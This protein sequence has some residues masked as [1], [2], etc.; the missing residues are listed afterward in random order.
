[1]NSPPL[2]WEGAVLNEG[3]YTVLARLG[4]GGMST[5]FR[6][7]DHHLNTD[8]VIKVPHALSPADPAFVQ[9]FSG[10]IRSLVHLAHPH[11]VQILDAG[12]HDGLPFAVL[13]YLSGGSLRGRQP[14]TPQGQ[15]FAMPPEHLRTWLAPVASA[16]DFIHQQGYVHRD[17]KPD[18]ILFDAHGN[19]YVAD[20]GVARATLSQRGANAAHRTLVGTP[21][22]LAPELLSGQPI[23]GQADQY[24]L[25]VTVHE[26]LTGR[27]PHDGP[28]PSLAPELNAALQKALAQEPS[29]R[30]PSCAAFAQAVLRCVKK[31]PA[32]AD[33]RDSR[34]QKAEELAPPMAALPRSPGVAPTVL[35]EAPPTIAVLPRRRWRK[36][37]W[38]AWGG[39]LAVALAAALMVILLS[40]PTPQPSVE[41]DAP[42]FTSKEPARQQPPAS[43]PVVNPPPVLP[44]HP[45]PTLPELELAAVP[46]TTLWAGAE[47]LVPVAVVRRH[48][49]GPI[50]V[51]VQGLPPLVTAAPVDVPAGQ[52]KTALPLRAALKALPATVNYRIVATA[53]KRKAEQTG[54][55]AVR[56]VG[57]LRS[58]PAPRSD[59]LALFLPSSLQA[60]V[61]GPDGFMRIV[62]LESGKI[63]RAFEN[64]RVAPLATCL[65]LSRDGRFALSGRG[66]ELVLWDVAGGQPER[67]F[68]LNLVP[69]LERLQ[70]V[71]L[72]PDG[73]YALAATSYQLLFQD[74]TRGIRRRFPT[75][76]GARSAVFSPLGNPVL[77]V[78][79]KGWLELFDVGSLH[80]IDSGVGKGR[81][82]P[83]IKINAAVFTPDGRAIAA[84]GRDRVI[85]IW[86]AAS[87]KEER[88]LLGHQAAV[89]CLTYTPD[90]RLLSAGGSDRQAT[91]DKQAAKGPMRQALDC[92]VRLWD[93][94]AAKEIHKYEG[95]LGRVTSL[96][97][98]GDGRFALSAGED[99]TIRLWG[100]P[101][102]AAPPAAPPGEKGSTRP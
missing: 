5:I 63:A 31:L 75:L 36:G 14:R 41:A 16:L 6:A 54:R 51:E 64:P 79:R 44:D 48:W 59:A 22:Y 13:Q 17:V 10:E 7:R 72:S 18:N 23:D 49:D 55:L 77:A 19:A 47:A 33:H 34:L 3:R 100:L 40:R 60:L 96:S 52:D 32:A 65:A 29:Q 8:V 85:R 101:A 98:S 62:D 73:R 94:A 66:N 90:G 11:V 78:S 56:F 58:F 15:A 61:T 86:D 27:Y 69:E 82:A 83:L 24:A 12:E 84:A 38:A 71:A 46:Q 92:T 81:Q 9:R 39:G 57:Q 102:P 28:G 91:N 99:G 67:R 21:P 68:T 76:G 80:E 20:F 89:W 95:H 30:F 25:A 26:L 87:G 37:R 1:M 97:A 50:H 93:V 42:A 4:E 35:A 45:P 88:R 43:H 53:G 70:S 74:L 2:A